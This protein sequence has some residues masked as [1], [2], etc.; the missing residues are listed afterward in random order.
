MQSKKFPTLSLFIVL[1]FHVHV[2]EV[3]SKKMVATLHSLEEQVDEHKRVF[4]RQ[5]P[6]VTSGLERMKGRLCCLCEACVAHHV[7]WRTAV[8]VRHT[9]PATVAGCV[10]C[11]SSYHLGSLEH[12][13]EQLRLPV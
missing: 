3:S 10:D 13:Q 6:Y 5:A 1:H 4:A 9:R 12:V 11:G 7:G 8:V 2:H